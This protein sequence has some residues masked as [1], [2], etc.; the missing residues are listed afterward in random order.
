MKRANGTGTI[1]KLSGNR[2]KPFRVRVTLGFKNGKQ[3]TEDVGCYE[4]RMDAEKAL[5]DYWNGMTG[6]KV[7]FITDGHFVKIGKANNIQQRLLFLQT[8]NP[9]K[10]KVLKV[11]SCKDSQEAF[12]L[13]TFFHH[14]FADK[15]KQSEWFD[16]PEIIERKVNINGQS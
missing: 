13:E 8:G 16:I 2:R 1:S 5:D 3:M 6:S 11:I 10:L 12:E 14:C 4:T 15:R 7:Y 9:N